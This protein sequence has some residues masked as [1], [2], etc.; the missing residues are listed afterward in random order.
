VQKYVIQWT[1]GLFFYLIV[2]LLD[3]GHKCSSPGAI[4]GGNFARPEVFANN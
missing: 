3:K 2:D 1:K 4:S